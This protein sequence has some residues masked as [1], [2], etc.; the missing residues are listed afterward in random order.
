M[1]LWNRHGSQ[2]VSV[3]L[4]YWFQFTGGQTMYFIL[5]SSLVNAITSVQKSLRNWQEFEHIFQKW[6]AIEHSM[7][8]VKLLT[9]HFP[10][11]LKA[12][13]QSLFWFQIC[14]LTCAIACGLILLFS[15]CDDKKHPA[16]LIAAIS[17]FSLMAYV[18]YENQQNLAKYYRKRF[19]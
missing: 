2:F 17:Q 10:P 13:I 3:Y 6:K 14:H 18:A 1:Y 8:M 16:I 4:D 15:N 12:L 19:L 5:I 11:K 7:I 9:T